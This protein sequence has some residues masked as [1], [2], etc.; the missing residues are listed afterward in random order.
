[1]ALYKAVMSAKR[2]K[3]ITQVLRFDDRTTR[4]ACKA[5]DPFTH[6]R[7][8][9][10]LFIANCTSYYN[11]GKCVTIDEQLLPFRGRCSFKMYIPSKPDN[12]GIKI[13]MLNDS[14]TFY[15]INAIPYVGKVNPAELEEKEGIPSY[16][17]RKLVEPIKN[18][19]RNITAD[20]WFMSVP[21]IDKVLK[22]QKLTMVG[23]V[24]KNKREIPSSFK[25]Y[26]KDNNCKFAYK[27]KKVLV[28]FNTK[29]K[30]CCFYQ[31]IIA[32]DP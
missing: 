30:L 15:M 18:S 8:I 14:E 10:N 1:M 3:F 6:I 2:F 12:Y 21:L 20:N 22:D 19:G 25:T 13:L 5:V 29:K 31:H 32:R 11:P 27:D 16:F 7:E 26:E 9:Q 17:V 24:K 28:S 4:V 23:T